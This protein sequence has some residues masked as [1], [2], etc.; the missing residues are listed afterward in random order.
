M[1]HFDEDNK[2]YSRFLWLA[3]LLDPE[4]ELPSVRTTLRL[5]MISP[6]V[7]H[8]T[9][10]SSNYTPVADEYVDDIICVYVHNITRSHGS[11]VWASFCKNCK[12]FL[13][14]VAKHDTSWSFVEHIYRHN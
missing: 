8:A 7:L 6:F 10:L 4:S 11:R 1:A 5:N 13:R 3:T 12:N 2:K 14:K 9:Y